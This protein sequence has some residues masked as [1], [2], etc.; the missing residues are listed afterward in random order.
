MAQR[1]GTCA[2]HKV[3]SWW[4]QSVNRRLRAI[5]GLRAVGQRRGGGYEASKSKGTERLGALEAILRL[6]RR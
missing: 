1:G 3:R 2:W 6:S 5:K 4:T